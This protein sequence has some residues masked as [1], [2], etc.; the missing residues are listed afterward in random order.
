MSGGVKLS[1]DNFEFE[2]SH[3]FREIVVVADT[4]IS[5]PG[6]GFGGGIGTLEGRLKIFDQVWEGP[7]QGGVE[8]CLGMDSSPTFGHSFS[9]EGE[10]VSNLF[11][12][13][14]IDVL[15]DQ[16]ISSD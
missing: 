8:G 10:G 16:E 13:C 7:K 14:G 6:G 2:F 5:E 1:F 15:V 11:I 9:H 3:I 12:V 4:G